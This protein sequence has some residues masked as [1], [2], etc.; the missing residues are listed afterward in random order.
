MP[1]GIS[2]D[3]TAMLSRTATARAMTR[4]TSA[5]ERRTAENAVVGVGAAGDCGGERLGEASAP[6]R[7]E[8]DGEGEVRG[9]VEVRVVDMVS[10]WPP[11]GANSR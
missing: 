3:P 4:A 8:G 9:I 7:A 2:F 1:S 11:R 5:A 10:F 6:R